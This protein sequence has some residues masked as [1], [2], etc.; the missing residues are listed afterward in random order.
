M[1]ENPADLLAGFYRELVETAN[2]DWQVAQYVRHHQNAHVHSA[3]EVIAAGIASIARTQ[4]G[5]AFDRAVE[6]Y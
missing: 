5:E 6:A 1:A 2:L 4:H 3:N